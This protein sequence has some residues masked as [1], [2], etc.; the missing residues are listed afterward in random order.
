[1]SDLPQS[2]PQPSQSIGSITSSG[3]NNK[4]ALGQAGRDANIDQSTTEVS[5]ENSDLQAALEAI[6]KLKQG[7]STSELLN[8]VEKKQ[9]EFTIQMLEDEIQKPKPDKNLIDQTVTALKK[10][11]RCDYFSRAS[12]SSC[13]T[14]G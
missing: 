3:S 6:Q 11:G 2:Q 13:G 5:V 1:M 12:D 9:T 8:L 10:V 14:G 4:I 7:V